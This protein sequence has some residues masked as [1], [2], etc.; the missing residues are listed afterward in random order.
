MSGKNFHSKAFDE[1]TQTKLEIFQLYTREWL[2]VFLSR[3][4]SWKIIHIYDFFSGPGVDVNGVEGSPVRTVKEILKF[5]SLMEKNGITIQLHFSDYET[6]KIEALK[7][8]VFPLLKGKTHVIALIEALDF[9]SAFQK[10]LPILQSGNSA[11]L[12]F[13]DPCGVNFIDQSKFQQLIASP[14]TDFLYFLA[15]SYLHRFREMPSIKLKIKRPDDFYHVHKVA[16]E[17]FKTFIPSGKDYYLA[18]FSIKKKKGIYGIIF[19]TGHP[20]GMDKF[21][22]TAWEKAP[23][24]GE[25]NFDI[26]REDFREDAPFLPIGDMFAVPNKLHAFEEDLRQAILS[27]KCTN[28]RDV[29]GICFDH[30]VRRR[31]AQVVL[32]TLKSEGKIQYQFRV[33]T[34]D[35]IPLEP[36]TLL[37]KSG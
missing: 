19:G 3:S 33:P 5:H 29:V 37:N 11:K 18:P 9:E 27:G 28:E 2:P 13:I 25:A 17:E 36:I 7:D 10:A 4:D 14:R 35:R 30:G 1:G 15:S 6:D 16:V 24:N 8:R 31:H 22:N 20:L 23:F 32:E 34:F 26:D 21:L 12:V